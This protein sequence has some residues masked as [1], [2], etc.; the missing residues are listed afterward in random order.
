MSAGWVSVTT[1]FILLLIP[2]GVSLAIAQ[3]TFA[4]LEGTVVDQT[5][6]RVSGV[7]ITIQNLE[8]NISRV[9]PTDNRGFYRALNLS[10]GTYRVTAQMA[11]FATEVEREVS[12]EINQ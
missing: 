2:S 10:V 3:S 8:T 6:G 5:E 12:L 9:T 4:S 11:G 7:S 1:L